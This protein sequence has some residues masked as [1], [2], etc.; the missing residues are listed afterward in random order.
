[1]DD[2]SIK[3]KMADRGPSGLF[4]FAMVC[5]EWRKAQLKVGGPLRSRVWFDVIMPGRGELVKWAL[6]E[7]GP[8][9]NADGAITMAAFA[10]SFGHFE[11]VQWLCGEQG[12][13]M[14]ETVIML[15]AAGGHLEVVQWLREE[16]CPWSP[17]TC[18]NAVAHGH[19]QFLRWVRENGC[20]WTADDRDRAAAELGYADDLG[21]L[22][23]YDGNP[24]QQT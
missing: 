21:N 10:A 20:Q 15:A 12:L 2:M 24:V 18:S 22:I 1:M 6:A 7:G 23:D 11:L 17:S 8:R 5:K 16:G 14:D 4:A 19:V 9:E 3:R 13:M